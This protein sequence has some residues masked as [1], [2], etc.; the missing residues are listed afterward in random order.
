MPDMSLPLAPIQLRGDL[1]ETIWGGNGLAIH[2]GKAVPP[3]ARVGESWETALRSVAMNSPY[4]GQTLGELVETLGERLIGWRPAELL[5][6]RF[7]LLT[8]FLD[9]QQWLS[10]QVHPDDLYAASH[11][12]GKLGK[13]ETWYIVHAEPGAQVALGLIHEASQ[14]E[15]SDAIATGSLEGLLRTFTVR[16]GDVIF[17]PAGTVHAIGPG[18]VLYEL[19][20]YSDVTYRLYDYGRVQA[21]GKPRELHIGKSLAVMSY[22][23]AETAQPVPVSVENGID[24]GDRRV[25]IAC[26][27]FLEEELRLRGTST[28]STLRSSCHIISVLE[29]T[30]DIGS[31]SAPLTLGPGDTVVIPAALVEYRIESG[32]G[33]HLLL[34]YV[35]TLDDPRARA[36]R[37]RQAKPFRSDIEIT[38]RSDIEIT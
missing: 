14:D 20:E 2:A 5:G 4:Q 19:Q 10:V 3:G 31:V 33:V 13:T 38:F 26:K 35:P 7:P 30:C 16:A 15:V 22:Q 11:E 6:H 12:G 27:H 9:A 18:I 25:L 23:P 8:K 1:H 37:E 32:A 24:G 34:S 36:W 21:D 17:V 29:G 28:E